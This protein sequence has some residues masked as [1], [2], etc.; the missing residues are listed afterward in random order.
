MK[1]RDYET[2]LPRPC[3]RLF[4]QRWAGVGG[5]VCVMKIVKQL[6]ENELPEPFKTYWKSKGRLYR[7]YNFFDVNGELYI[8]DEPDE[9]KRSTLLHHWTDNS[10]CGI[11]LFREEQNIPSAHAPYVTVDGVSKFEC[12]SSG[13]YET[14]IRDPKSGQVW[15]IHEG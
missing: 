3:H 5:D 7:D 1:R 15:V 14:S 2:L 12:F 8:Q 4:P 13:D 11:W 6:H 10:C 9:G